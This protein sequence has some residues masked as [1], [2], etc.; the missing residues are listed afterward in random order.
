[1]S[2]FHTAGQP[3]HHLSP[4]PSHPPK[5]KL[6]A[7]SALTP[8]PLSSQSLVPT[9]LLCLYESA[10]PAPPRTQA[11][12]FTE[13][14]QIDRRKPLPHSGMRGSHPRVSLHFS[15][16]LWPQRNSSVTGQFRARG[17][18]TG[19]PQKWGLP[20][21]IE[22]FLYLAAK[23]Y[24]KEKKKENFR[25]LGFGSKAPEILRETELFKQSGSS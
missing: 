17:Q 3:H 13:T 14:S 16:N 24:F 19:W 1:M 7:R 25:L 12:G 4:E 18:N 9:D 21:L 6:C 22:F 23:L 15:F 20:H 8:Q 10:V 2:T 11:S 5:L